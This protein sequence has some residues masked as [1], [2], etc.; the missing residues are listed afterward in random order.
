MRNLTV[1]QKKLLKEWFNKYKDE[2][3]GFNLVDIL[4]RENIELYEQLEQINDTEAL[5][6]NINSFLCDLLHNQLL[7]NQ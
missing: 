4:I 6:Q 5:Y 7:H 1:K 2:L 3:Y